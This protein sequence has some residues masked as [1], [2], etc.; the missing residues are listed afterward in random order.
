MSTPFNV[1]LSQPDLI[2]IHIY[3]VFTYLLIVYRLCNLL[4][5][6]KT[7]HKLLYWIN[8]SSLMVQKMY[9]LIKI[10][11]VFLLNLISLVKFLVNSHN[12]NQ[13]LPGI[14]PLHHQ[15]I[16][17]QYVGILPKTTRLLNP[18]D[19]LVTC[20]KVTGLSF[21]RSSCTKHQLL[22]YVTLVEHPWDP[23]QNCIMASRHNTLCILSTDIMAEEAMQE[24]KKRHCLCRF[25]ILQLV[26][27]CMC[28][29]VHEEGSSMIC[30]AFCGGVKVNY[31]PNL[32][33][34]WREWCSSTL[35]F[36]SFQH[37]HLLTSNRSDCKATTW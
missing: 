26:N 5:K 14:Q 25:C 36:Y 21:I 10:L 19:L 13:K 27:K 35:V 28:T 32:W 2:L 8:I 17:Q 9:S 18:F 11:V 1:H 12:V 3:T 15:K 31:A 37:S 7:H 23:K 34:F 4:F 20:N 29:F 30:I 16:K 33:R 24:K 6:G 22:Q